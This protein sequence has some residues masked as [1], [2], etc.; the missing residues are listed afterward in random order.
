VMSSGV[1]GTTG[2]AWRPS[3]KQLFETYV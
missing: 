1:I 2:K 3:I